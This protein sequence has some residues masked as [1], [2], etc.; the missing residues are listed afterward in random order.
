MPLLQSPVVLHTGPFVCVCVR[1]EAEFVTKV[2]ATKIENCSD[3]HL[4][5]LSTN[6]KSTKTLVP[7]CLEFS[8]L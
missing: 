5:S 2:A 3:I 8:V 4:S 7:A 6:L 1:F